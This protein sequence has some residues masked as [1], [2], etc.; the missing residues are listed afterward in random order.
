L[1]ADLAI[2]AP[3]T[4]TTPTFSRARANGVTPVPASARAAW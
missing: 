4:L 3:F 1:P 2:L